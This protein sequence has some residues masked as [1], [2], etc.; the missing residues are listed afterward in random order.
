MESEKEKREKA[1]DNMIVIA[2]EGH[3]SAVSNLM[4]KCSLSI[5]S[6]GLLFARTSDPDSVRYFEPVSRTTNKPTKKLKIFEEL[7]VLSGEL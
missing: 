6:F 5:K 4:G 7:K 2:K 3:S 1:A